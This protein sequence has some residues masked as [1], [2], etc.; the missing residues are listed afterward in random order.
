V[1]GQ[2]CESPGLPPL[3]FMEHTRL[4]WQELS[5]FRQAPKLRLDGDAQGVVKE[6]LEIDP[7]ID[8]RISKQTGDI[9]VYAVDDS[10]K[11]YIVTTAKELDKCIVHTVRQI[12]DMSYDL[13]KAADAA[14][15]AAQ[16]R[17]EAALGEKIREKGEEL[18]WGFRRD[19][20]L[21]RDSQRSKRSWGKK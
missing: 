10:D 21:Y 19:L 12:R 11:E 6:L 16:K 18:A 15:D 17:Q 8:V 4:T 5:E 3:T 9:V 14:D 13:A 1:V 7:S 20:G 2:D